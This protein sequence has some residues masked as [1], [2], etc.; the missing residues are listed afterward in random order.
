MQKICLVFIIEW[1]CLFSGEYLFYQVIEF[2]I[3]HKSN[4]MSDGM[5]HPSCMDWPFYILIFNIF[6]Y[7]KIIFILINNKIVSSFQYFYYKNILITIILIIKFK[8]IYF[9]IIYYKKLFNII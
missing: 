5:S 1:K 2:S 7:F 9:Y 4:E 6:I 8:I 3:H